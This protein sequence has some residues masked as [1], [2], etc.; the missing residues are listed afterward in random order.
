M[1]V[2]FLDFDGALYG[3]HYF[4][5]NGIRVSKSEFEKRLKRRI[6]I[7]GEIC[8]E[9]DAKIVIES[10]YKDCIDEET[11]ETDVDWIKEILDLMKQNGIEVIGRTPNLK[12]VRD[13]YDG[14]PPIWKEDEILGYLKKHPEID[15]YCVIDDDDLVTI[16]ARERKDYSK[17]DFKQSKRSFIRN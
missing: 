4:Y 6:K 3:L 17:S 1:K 7:L 10:S 14:N 15:S 8:K 11:L 2:I 12:D 13:N 5:D 16:P 9:N